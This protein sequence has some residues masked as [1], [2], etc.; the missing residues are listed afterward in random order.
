MKVG[1][2]IEKFR[3]KFIEKAEARFGDKFDYSKVEYTTNAEKVTILCKKHGEFE[4]TPG[5]FLKL[6]YGCRDCS[7]ENMRKHMIKT[8]EQFILRA[9]TVHGKKYMYDLVEFKGVKFDVIIICRVHGQFTQAACL[10]LNG[11]GCRACNQKIGNR[12]YTTETFLEV[13]QKTHGDSLDFSLV[14][15]ANGHEHVTV[16]CPKHGPYQST[17][18]NILAGRGCRKCADKNN[19]V[20][21]ESFIARSHAIHDHKYT[22]ERTI[23]ERSDKPVMITCPKH[24]DFVQRASDHLAGCGCYKCYLGAPSKKAK[25]WL[26]WMT[27]RTGLH[28]QH[29]GNGGE[30]VIPGSRFKADGFSRD[31]KTVFEFCG[32]LWHGSPL[33]YKASDP[34]P[35]IKNKTH[36]EVYQKTINRLEWIRQQGYTVEVIWEQT[37]DAIVKR[38]IKIQRAW[39]AYKG[40]VRRK[41]TRSDK[42]SK[43]VA[44]ASE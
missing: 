19:C 2:H 8:K 25:L 29:A 20:P 9:Q 36:G 15:Y 40:I 6:T 44:K 4:V 1:A 16:I 23:Y 22:Y 30:F 14:T 7:K 39:R 11:C 17:P 18:Q 27:V 12:R 42:G 41:K 35:F 38:A 34:H 5:S 26:E 33:Y 21:L 3:Q 13:A 24:G 37:F 32:R 31:T 43:R 10:H 28:I